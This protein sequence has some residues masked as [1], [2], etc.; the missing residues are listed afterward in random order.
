M[1]LTCTQENLR[2][3]VAA[4]ERVV[5]RQATL[6]ILGNFLL[7]TENGR[8]KISATNLELG[9][10]VWV[11]AKVVEEGRVTVPAR[12][13]SS[14]IANLPADEV[15]TMES[16]G[17]TLHVSGGRYR[18]RI[19]GLDAKDFPLMPQP[20]NTTPLIL[21]AQAFKQAL[22]RIL[23]CVATQETRLE[24][25]GVSVLFG[26]KGIDLAATDSF[27]LA[28]DVLV[29]DWGGNQALTQIIIPAHTLAE[30]V[31]G[32]DVNTTE[33]KMI[34]EEN[35]LFFDVDGVRIVSRLI[36]G[37][38]PDYK[39]IIPERFAT[40]VGVDRELFVRAVRIA[41][42]F[43]SG[44]AR[45]VVLKVR[46]KES[47]M[48]VESRSQESGENQTKVPLRVVS[49]DAD[50]EYIFNA[51]YLMD[52]IQ[53]VGTDEVL[54]CVNENIAPA[55]LKPSQDGSSNENRFLYI[56]MPIRA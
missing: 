54:L 3:A 9:L 55:A 45:E 11:G 46:P 4:A 33:V 30:V 47:L 10:L 40:N 36:T 50:G 18:V 48:V 2:K 28:E 43:A 14:F 42:L 49:G 13:L 26:K 38:F 20:K 8:L 39:Q 25:M 5:G 34:V 32:V 35:Q 56:L 37:R 53:S 19:N 23:P 17:Q 1:K 22:S 16:E 51:Q 15:V 24:L 31:R 29:F 41:S 6:P 27:R 12:L 52:G 44:T 21:P 7:E